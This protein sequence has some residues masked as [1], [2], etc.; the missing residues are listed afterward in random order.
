LHCIFLIISEGGFKMSFNKVLTALFISLL[1]TGIILSGCTKQEEKIEKAA[2][3]APF[4]DPL[5]IDTGY[6]S[7][8]LIGDVDNPIRAYRGIPYAAP[9]VG[10]LR[11]K[12]P[13]P[14]APWKEIRQCTAFTKT[15][16]QAGMVGLEQE[17]L[18]EDCLYLNVMTPA[19][20]VGESLPVM[21]WLHGGG[22]SSGSGNDQLCN[23]HRLPQHGVVLVTVTMRLN[24]F[25]LLAHPLLTAESPDNSS[26]NYMFLDMIVALNWVKRNISVFGGNP[27]NVTIFGES[28][29]GSKVSTLMSSPMASGLFHRAICES[30]T[31]IGGFLIGK[32]LKEMEELGVKLFAKLGVNDADDPLKAARALPFEKIM[33]ARDAMMKEMQGDRRGMGLDDSTIDGWFLPKSPLEL[34]KSGKYN[35][36]PLIT[37]A[38]LGEI[39]GPGGL[40]LPQLIPA[41]VNMHEFQN[42]A[43]AKGYAAIF[44]QVP[45][46]WRAAGAVS[47]HAMEVLYVFGDYD[48]RSG[49]W[50]LMYGLA[51]Q[52]GAKGPNDPGLSEADRRVSEAMMKMWAQFAKT[53]DPNT[54]GMVQW[55]VYNKEED[56]YM[57]IADPLEIKTGFSNI[58]PVSGE[59]Q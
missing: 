14:V 21:V 52:S 40:L 26:G 6:I 41:Y 35:A 18:S 1:S 2:A 33:E 27:D 36:V 45:G 10:D 24:T 12:P 3:P 23:L 49:W 56:K 47:T 11:W 30:G 8:T 22:Y 50:P 32:D 37:V 7:G 13:Q 28:G 5:K 38:N 48:N 19:R 31:S 20:T 46:K 54:P 57:Y 59:Q 42:K 58:K 53:G 9:P 44:D 25:G 39:T 16:P 15:P 4:S 29:G 34:F 51:S 43:G 17:P 55:P